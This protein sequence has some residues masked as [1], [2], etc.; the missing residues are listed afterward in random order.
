MDKMIDL[1]KYSI[2]VPLYLLEY[3]FVC[4]ESIELLDNIQFEDRIEP[5]RKLKCNILVGESTGPILSF[6]GKYTDCTSS[7]FPLLDRHLESICTS[8]ISKTDEFVRS[9]I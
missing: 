3:T 7:L 5:T 4:L 6:F 8:I 1:G 2:G 9:K